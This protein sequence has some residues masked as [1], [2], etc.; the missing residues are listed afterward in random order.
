MFL[1]RTSKDECPESPTKEGKKEEKTETGEAY[2]LRNMKGKEKGRT[3]LN[4]VSPNR[5]PMFKSLECV[6]VTLF[7]KSLCK[8]N[9]VQDLERTAS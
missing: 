2:S 4:S 5:C 3:E 1:V 8:C 7:G 9:Q 6:H